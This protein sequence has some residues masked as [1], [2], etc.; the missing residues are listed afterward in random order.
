MIS[1]SGHFEHG[2]AHGAFERSRASGQAA[3]RCWRLLPTP[4]WLG[5]VL[6]R[7]F[8]RDGAR[9]R[10][11][12]ASMS[13]RAEGSAPPVA[14]LRPT[15]LAASTGQGRT[16]SAGA[17]PNQSLQRTGSR[18]AA[19]RTRRPAA[20]RQLVRRPATKGTLSCIA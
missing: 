3:A 14:Q 9:G 13:V 8:R 4:P 5:R 17:Q 12:Q 7:P 16:A 18:A 19:Y 2:P 10:N 20:E 15:L 1:C 11:T 6:G